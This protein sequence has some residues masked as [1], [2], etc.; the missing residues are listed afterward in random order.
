MRARIQ[1]FVAKMNAAAAS[2]GASSTHFVDASGYDPHSVSTAADCLRIAAAGMVIPT[3]AAVVGMTTV[4]LPLVGTVHNLVTEIGSNGVVGVKSGYTS[5]AGGCMVLAADRVVDGRTV[6]VLAAVLGQP[7]PPPSFRPPPRRPPHRP[8]PRPPPRPPRPPRPRP[9]RRRGLRPPPPH[10]RPPHRLPPCR[11][12][13]CPRRRRSTGTVHSHDHHPAQRPDRAGSLP[14]HPPG[15]RGPAV[16][17][18][19]RRGPPPAD[20]LRPAGRDGHRCLGWA[21]APGGGGRR[22]SAWL[23]GW[24]GQRAT[25]TTKV[26]PVTAGGRGGTRWGPPSTGS[27]PRSSR[28]RCDWRP[29]SPSPRGGGGLSTIDAVP[30]IPCR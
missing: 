20:Q 24:P 13:P 16:L 21:S 4:T 8:R 29:P 23:L 30:L 22:R 9:H 26:E 6:L 10:R 14:L 7:V 28:C 18:R 5:Y 1:A 19:G 2:L 27:A 25:A 12:P 15:R 3:F 11:L 17:R